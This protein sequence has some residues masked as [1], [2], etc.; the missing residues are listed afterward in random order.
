[1]F[2]GIINGLISASLVGLLFSIAKICFQQLNVIFFS[3]VV[4]GGT[5]LF[6]LVLLL[7][8]RKG[9]QILSNG[10]RYPE[11][12]LVGLFAAA[13][14][15]ME[16]WGLKL[17]SPTNAS[18]LLRGDLFFSLVIGYFLWKEKLR[19]LEW[20]GM[21][22]MLAG[23]A[24]VLQISLYDLRFGTPGD[25]LILSSAFL[26][27]VNAE[28]IKH[29]LGKVDNTVVAFFNSGICFVSYL[30]GTVSSGSIWP[31]P[32]ASVLVWSL[33]IISIAFQIV[34][35]LTYYHA[36]R[37]LSTW[38]V[39]VFLLA[40]PVVAIISSAW[41]LHEVINYGQILGMLLLTVGISLI[42]LVERKKV[43]LF[44]A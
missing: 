12:Y 41:W 19:R 15:L 7:A 38:L 32:K 37:Q 22:I 3:M 20:L 42:C 33:V 2:F 6:F 1:M 40:T 23:I 30:I 14:N 13:L 5:N 24:M 25:G 36:L 39:R 28:I 34:Q 27:A 21:G 9:A 18:I 17:S 31:L 35:Y 10:K 44:K 11:L 26:L 16:N 29:R 8:Q 4:L 43:S